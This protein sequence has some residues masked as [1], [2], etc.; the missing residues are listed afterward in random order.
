VYL[1]GNDEERREVLAEIYNSYVRKDVID[2]MNIEK[3]AAGILLC[4]WAV[5]EL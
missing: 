5:H 3:V 1:P 2:L 4:F